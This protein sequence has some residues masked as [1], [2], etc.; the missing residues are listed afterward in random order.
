MAYTVGKIL[1]DQNLLAEAA[2][3]FVKVP[4]G[5]EYFMRAAYILA[6]MKLH[7]VDIKDSILA[8]NAIEKS[9]VIAVEDTWVRDLAILAQGRIFIDA[10]LIRE[11]EKA[12]LRVPLTSAFAESASYELIKGLIVR[13][14]LATSGLG[15]FQRTYPKKSKRLSHSNHWIWL[16]G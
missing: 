4:K 8:F 7:K 12:Y 3:L 10:G 6:A 2:E 1:Y 5:D 13:S 15:A 16:D 9:P 11:A 14:E